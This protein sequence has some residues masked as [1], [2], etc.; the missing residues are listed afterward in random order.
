MKVTAVSRVSRLSTILAIAI[1]IVSKTD[2]GSIARL[3]YDNIGG[4]TVASLTNASIFPDGPTFREQLDDFTPT[5]DGTVVTGLQGKDNF[6]S[7]YGAYIRGYLE[8]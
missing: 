1:S 4:A 7:N 3:V 5:P 6:G 8:A 2:A